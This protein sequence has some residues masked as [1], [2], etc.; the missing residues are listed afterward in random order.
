ME[1]NHQVCSLEWAKKLKDLGVKQESLFYYQNNPY[2]D[3]QDCIDLMVK[4][5]KGENSQNVIMNSECENDDHPKYSAF[6]VADLGEILKMF[7]I[8]NNKHLDIDSYITYDFYNLVLKQTKSIDFESH[9]IKE[10]T[11][12]N[13]RAKI[14]IHL[15][16]NDLWKPDN[17]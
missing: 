11:E 8:F 13:A 9:Y 4:E 2:N 10:K 5:W 14:L 16:E 3:G 7:V 12:A 1:L 15:I 17:G 6:T